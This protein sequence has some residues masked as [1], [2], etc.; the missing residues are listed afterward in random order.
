MSDIPYRDVDVQGEKPGGRLM[1]ESYLGEK[2]SLWSWLTTTDHKRIGILYVLSTTLFF[3]IGGAAATLIRLELFTPA[4]DLLTDDG[5]NKVFTL[6]GVVMVW[7][8]LV[9]VIP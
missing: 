9:P 1:E 5:Y 7:F 3:F 4:G 8:F 6:H 2:F